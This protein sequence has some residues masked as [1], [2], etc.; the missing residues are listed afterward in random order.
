MFERKY[1]DVIKIKKIRNRKKMA[2]I[3]TH[4]FLVNDRYSNSQKVA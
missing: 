3:E 2:D 1:N 4:I